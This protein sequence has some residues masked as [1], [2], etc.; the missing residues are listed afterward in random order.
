MRPSRLNVSWLP[1]LA[2]H[3]PLP[4]SL[5]LTLLFKFLDVYFSITVRI[6]DGDR[7]S[8]SGTDEE[9]CAFYEIA[10]TRIYIVQIDARLNETSKR[11]RLL[12]VAKFSDN[13]WTIYSSVSNISNSSSEQWMSERAGFVI[14]YIATIDFENLYKRIKLSVSSNVIS[15]AYRWHVIVWHLILS[16]VRG[17]Y[18]YVLHVLYLSREKKNNSRLIDGKL[19][20]FCNHTYICCANYSMYVSRYISIKNY[21]VIL[22]NL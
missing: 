9:I 7:E 19:A 8:K 21:I 4:P 2:V 10:I 5:P 15:F 14:Q 11:K 20:T 17:I 18:T 16:I 22:S 12:L 3:W 6:G 1:R 13:N